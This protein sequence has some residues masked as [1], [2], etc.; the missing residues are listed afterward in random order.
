[1]AV[2]VLALQ[3]GFAAHARALAAIGV[4]PVEVRSAAELAA[5]DGLV[6]P[7]GESGTLLKLIDRFALG[8]ALADC[9]ARGIPILGTC[10]GLILLAREV[11][12]AQASLGWLD[13]VVERNAYGRQLDSFEADDDAGAMRLVFIRAPR[14][15]AVGEGCRVLATHRGEPV[16]VAQRNVVGATFH[17]E[18]ADEL[19]VH[20]AVFGVRDEPSMVHA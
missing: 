17:P 2:G 6:L 10:A 8:A 18:L 12:P 1:M 13:V 3:G 19:G 7:G 20:R 15:R 11:L 5:I 16:L 14:I 4:E 9:H